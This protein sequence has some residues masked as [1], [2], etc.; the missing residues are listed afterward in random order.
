[1]FVAVPGARG[2][3]F[4]GA[5]IALF[6]LLLTRTDRVRIISYALDGY[7]WD[8]DFNDF[9]YQNSRVYCIPNSII[10]HMGG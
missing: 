8:Y 5:V 1:M 9:L 10:E 2:A 3:E 7:D 4:E 6:H